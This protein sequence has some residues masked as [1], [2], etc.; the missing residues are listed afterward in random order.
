MRKV[1]AFAVLMIVTLTSTS[2]STG[3]GEEIFV[4]RIVFSVDG[5]VKDFRGVQ[6]QQAASNNLYVRAQVGSEVIEAIEFEV[7]K[8]VTGTSAVTNMIFTQNNVEFYALT[9]TQVT[10]TRNDEDRKIEGNFSGN[11]RTLSGTSKFIS[12]GKFFFQY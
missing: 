10:V 9:G 11:F 12:N 6:V 5:I 2:C 1:L 8:N 7:Q 4:N 3:S